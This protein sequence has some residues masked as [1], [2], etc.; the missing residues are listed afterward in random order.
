MTK[1]GADER[2]TH[3]N[4]QREGAGGERGEERLGV[5][6]HTTI[7]TG[8]RTTVKMEEWK[9]KDRQSTAEERLRKNK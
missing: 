5:T 8:M 9:R 6:V 4:K 1:G 7:I 3:S 2:K